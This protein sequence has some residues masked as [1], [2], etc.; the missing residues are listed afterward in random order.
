MAISDKYLF[1][2]PCNE[3]TG[4]TAFDASGNGND[5]LAQSS[6]PTMLT[7]EAGYITT[8]EAVISGASEMPTGPIA[9]DLF[10]GDS[11]IW[12]MFT[13]S[14]SAALK[15]AGDQSRGANSGNLLQSQSGGLVSFVVTPSATQVPCLS[16]YFCFDDTD[17]H[18]AVVVDG[19]SR[20]V[21]IYIDGVL[22]GGST[23]TEHNNGGVGINFL[24]SILV[25]RQSANDFS[26]GN[27]GSETSGSFVHASKWFGIHFLTYPSA[28]LPINVHDIVQ[29]T[30]NNPLVPLDESI[31]G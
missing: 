26:F 16:R 22:G 31:A 2:L 11:Y 4:T 18:I 6:N 10:S 20:C 3:G 30:M 7:A 9:F 21:S 19:P 1:M 8:L 17:H 27:P 5:L 13:K 15:L 23:G 25:S 29:E 24:A 14:P 28:D 12:T